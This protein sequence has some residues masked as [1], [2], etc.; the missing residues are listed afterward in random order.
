MHDYDYPGGVDYYADASESEAEDDT[1]AYES[2][3][4]VDSEGARGWTSSE[5]GP[6]DP[7]FDR[8]GDE[9]DPEDEVAREMIDDE[10]GNDAAGRGPAAE[11]EEIMDEVIIMKL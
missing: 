11:A 6:G 9:T 7:E 1:S 8:E 5:G 2:S 4:E 10:R 3:S